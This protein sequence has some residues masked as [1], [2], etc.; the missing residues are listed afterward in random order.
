MGQKEKLDERVRSLPNDLK[1]SDFQ[2]FLEHNGFTLERVRGSHYR[3]SKGDKMVSI[4]VPHGKNKSNTVAVY[5][6]KTVLDI[7]DEE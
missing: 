2:K 7:L 1:F 6:I 5:Q 4:S 3:Y